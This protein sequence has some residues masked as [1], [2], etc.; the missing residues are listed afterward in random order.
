M[1]LQESKELRALDGD[2]M[3]YQDARRSDKQAGCLSQT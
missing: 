3:V 2:L 1:P